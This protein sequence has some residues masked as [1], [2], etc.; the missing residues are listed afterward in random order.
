[1]I[2]RLLLAITIGVV[3]FLF[4]IIFINMFGGDDDET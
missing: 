4:T 3:W 1:M 2:A